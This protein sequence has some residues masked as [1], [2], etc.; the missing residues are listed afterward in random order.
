MNLYKTAALVTVFAAF[1]H[2]LGFLYR[3]ILSRTLGPEGLGIYQV[4]LTVFAVFL[5]ISSSGM[6]ITL[7]RIISKHRARGSRIGEHK[8]TTAAILLTAS[9]SLAITLLLFLVRTPFSTIF[10]DPRCADL[11]YILIFSLSFTSV[12]AIIR[13]NFWGNKRFFA[14]SLI[15]L[16]EEIV[17]IIVGVLLLLFVRSEVADVNK[18]A[19][20]VLISYLAS[21]AIALIYFMVK[22]GKFRSPRGEIKPLVKSALPV[23]VMRA[24]SSLVNSAISVIFPMRLVQSG[25]TSA[26]AMS[27]YGIVG[28]MVM[29]VLMI[30]SSLIG[31]IAL[32]IVPE[33]SESYYRGNREKLSELA[34]KALNATLLIAGILIPLFISCGEGVGIFLF[35][36][37]ESGKLITQSAFILLPMSVT[38]ILTSVLNSMNC[39][40][41]T[42]LFFLLGSSGMLLCVWFLPSYLGSGALLVGMAAD[43]CVTA[44]CS[45]ILLTKKTGKLRSGKYLFSLLLAVFICT[46]VGMGLRSLL[47]IY[48]D[49]IWALLITM[50]TVLGLEA[51]FSHFFKLFDFAAAFKKFFHRS[52]RKDPAPPK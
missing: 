3:I 38:M 49:Y 47:M 24:S 20:A 33:L 50:L 37:A 31:S 40:R 43:Y 13:G 29:P 26:R 41:E 51:L 21:F 28:G 17:M 4:A 15:E 30:P 11:F 2:G 23:T 39:E 5:T 9:F 32:V 35:S 42:L 52:L 7:S 45:L 18:A 48:L 14:Y 36:N 22:G 19:A 12:Y 44:L 6:P 27:T 16:I 34:A 8:A 46:L 10:S 25:M 1:E